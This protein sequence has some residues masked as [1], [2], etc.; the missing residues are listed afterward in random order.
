MIKKNL[1]ENNCK[2]LTSSLLSNLTKDEDLLIGIWEIPK[3]FIFATAY[4][5]EETL[6][7]L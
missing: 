4:P 1:R 7:K 6:C 2:L 3:L 5:T